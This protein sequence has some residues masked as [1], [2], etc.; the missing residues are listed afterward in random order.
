MS[1]GAD[2]LPVGEIVEVEESQDSI[3][4]DQQIASLDVKDEI[5]STSINDWLEDVEFETTEDVPIPDRL[6]DQV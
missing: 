2:D 3:S 6:I 1:G 5:I 4:I